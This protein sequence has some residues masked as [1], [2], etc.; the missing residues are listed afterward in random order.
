MHRGRAYVHA[1][2]WRTIAASL[3]GGLTQ[4]AGSMSIL[5][6]PS[7]MYGHWT[8]CDPRACEFQHDEIT[9]YVL[10]NEEFPM[11]PRLERAQTTIDQALS[12]IKSALAFAAE[13]S[14]GQHPEFWRN[15]SRI[16]LR[17]KP[18]IVFSLRYALDSDFPVYEISWN[19]CFEAEF[20]VVYSDNWTEEQISVPLPDSRD[21]IHVRRIG[22]HRYEQVP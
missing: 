8:H 9:I 22:P 7:N 11:A 16:V 13:I 20:G 1:L 6:A 5:L 17:Q 14:S 4:A 19:P 21:F 15:A 12:E 3:R 10:Y 2:S 18:L